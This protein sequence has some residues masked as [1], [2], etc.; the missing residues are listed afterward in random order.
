MVKRAMEESPSK[1]IFVE[2]AAID[3]FR[4]IE[5]QVVG[6]GVSKAEHLWE[7]E[8]SIQ[9]RYQ[10]IIEVAPSTISD[11]RLVSK[12]IEAALRM[13]NEIRYFSLGTF[14][15]LCNPSTSE[16]FFLEVNPRLQVEHTVTESIT[17][18]DIVKIQ[19]QLAQGAPLRSTAVGRCSR[20]P[21]APPPLSSI[22]LR[23]TAESV[24]NDWSLSIG[25]IRSFRFPTGNGIRIDTHLINGHPTVVTADFDSLLAKI[26]VTAAT[27]EDAVRKAR[28]ALLDIDIKG[29]KTNID[30]LRG[31]ISTQAFEKGE[32]DT[33]WLEA[34]LAGILE[35]GQQLLPATRDSFFTQS[36]SSE[37]SQNLA[38]SNILFRKGDAWSLKLTPASN[39]G[40]TATSP[41]S[42]THHL[43]LDKVTRNDFPSTFVAD[44]LYTTPKSE[45]PEPY[46]LELASTSASSSALM[47]AGKHRRGDVADPHHV[48]IPFPGKLIEVLVDEGDV[49]QA[50]DVIL[51]VRQMKMELEVRTSRGGRIKWL[52]EVEDGEDV[53][54]GMLAA[55][56][57]DLEAP[58]EPRTLAKL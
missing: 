25:K 44:I 37:T 49:V 28:R 36:P 58:L 56:L 24:E 33:R 2:K 10:K 1:Q 55:E 48:V 23:L 54:D 7:R 11:R 51:V 16:F 12:I 17:F 46:K 22:Q 30:V 53:A 6:D 20:N 5:V 29:V 52:T 32:C 15:F 34:N 18:L 19:L 4:H 50:E 45:T 3:G 27:W 13:A 9:R 35:N 26:I 38:N 41:L 31:V 39:P 47:A 8:C 40:L 57:E 21:E 42:V 43:K 14:E